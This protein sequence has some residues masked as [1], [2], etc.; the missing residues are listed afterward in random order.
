MTSSLT[1]RLRRELDA[2]EASG[3]RRVLR[4]SRGIDFSSNDYLGLSGHPAV[5]DAVAQAA[6]EGTPHGSTGSRLLSG[7]QEEHV[8]VEDR[9]ATFIGRERALLFGSGF[10]ANL[11]LLS[12]L[13]GRHD[14]IVLDES[15]HASLKEGARASLASRRT[16]RHNDLSALEHA[17]RDREAFGDVFVVVEGVYSMDGDRAA[18][19]G[20]GEIAGRYSAHLVV[21]EA[22]A[23]GL[24]GENLRGVHETVPNILPLATVHPCGKALGS[25]G[26]FVAADAVVI[27]YLVNT[28]RP[29]L[30]STAPA[31]LQAVALGAVLDLLPSVGDR[32]ERVFALTARLRER[33]GELRRWRTID[34]ESPIV[35]V[36]IGSDA[37]SVHAGRLVQERGL[38]VR[39][40]RP[41][42]VRS[43]TA[44]LRISVVS[45][46]TEEEI[47]RLA[48]AVIEAERIVIEERP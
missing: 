35:P 38:D 12:A 23:T 9:F 31:P 43:G 19:E 27:D 10:A 36:V 18:L 48:D 29:F 28:A 45:E 20:I 47:D 41:P 33:L 16:F 15:A 25:S 14:L 30:F 6:R 8:A 13:P 32:V 7:N 22:H 5:L 3:L 1:E 39:P 44:R 4:C 11:A 46:R 17:L 2:R 26:A 42:T 34:S 21:D 24:Y 37:A 40:I